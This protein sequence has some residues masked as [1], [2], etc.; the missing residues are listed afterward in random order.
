L[1]FFGSESIDRK[2]LSQLDLAVE[3]GE[4]SEKLFSL[5]SQRLQV[6]SSFMKPKIVVMPTPPKRRV[7]IRMGSRVYEVRVNVEIA[8]VSLPGR[9]S[10]IA[11]SNQLSPTSKEL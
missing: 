7:R 4:I 10:L 2:R 9:P 5:S 3:L 11:M 8:P 6:R 1:E